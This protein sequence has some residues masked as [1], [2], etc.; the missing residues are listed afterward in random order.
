MQKTFNLKQYTK[1][2]FY[3]G[4]NEYAVTNSRCW[5]NCIKAKMEG[6]NKSMQEASMEC[7]KEYQEKGDGKWN[8]D[9]AACNMNKGENVGLELPEQEKAKKGK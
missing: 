8:L 5:P 7:L 2:A 1:K 4:V 9:Y 3:E 6:K